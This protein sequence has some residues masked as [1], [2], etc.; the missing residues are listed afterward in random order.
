MHQIQQFKGGYANILA[1]PPAFTPLEKF[2]QKIL[3]VMA[4]IP[5]KL[6]VVKLVLKMWSN[7]HPHTCPDI[8]GQ[9]Y[10]HR[11]S[12]HLTKCKL[13][14]ASVLHLVWK[15]LLQYNMDQFSVNG[16]IFASVQHPE[17]F[18][19]LKKKKILPKTM[20]LMI[21]ENRFMK[22][23]ISLWVT[24]NRTL[25][26]DPL[27]GYCQQQTH[28]AVVGLDEPYSRYLLMASI[29]VTSRRWLCG[30]VSEIYKS[31]GTVVRIARISNGEIWESAEDQEGLGQVF[32]MRMVVGRIEDRK[33]LPLYKIDT[34]KTAVL[35]DPIARMPTKFKHW[36]VDLTY[37]IESSLNSVKNRPP[38]R[39][40]GINKCAVLSMSVH[41]T[42]GD[43]SKV[44]KPD[45]E[46]KSTDTNT[47]PENHNQWMEVYKSW[48][49][50][51]S[52]A[53]GDSSSKDL[54]AT[55]PDSLDI[56]RGK[57]PTADSYN[58][59]YLFE[60]LD[61]IGVKTAETGNETKMDLVKLST[62]FCEVDTEDWT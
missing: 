21:R 61:E 20:I 41:E 49:A 28:M 23:R 54:V 26:K 59:N 60:G 19:D 7:L 55:I 22:S 50:K 31:G 10:S 6:F 37:K 58:M 46:S 13:C 48:L 4:A 14:M 15:K 38:K 57:S 5:A 27:S 42:M 18:V 8:A 44:F 35:I 45:M 3:S 34:F 40:F 47:N 33:R 32:V 16:D 36:S 52:M 1:L 2:Q 56:D 51:K 62:V 11:T 17:I 53:K 39:I 9:L 12:N 25:T 43:S 24:R 29:N 30:W